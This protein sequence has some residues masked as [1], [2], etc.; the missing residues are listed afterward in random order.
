MQWLPT[1]SIIHENSTIKE[2]G[3]TVF[4]GTQR[5]GVVCCE[6]KYVESECR[7]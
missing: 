4:A 1:L 6:R 3:W 7:V 2:H 5:S